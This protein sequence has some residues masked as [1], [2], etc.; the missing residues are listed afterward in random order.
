ME[1]PDTE[2]FA[3]VATCK[4]TWIGSYGFAV[5]T[6]GFALSMFRLEPS[7]GGP[8]E[9]LAPRLGLELTTH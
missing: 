8:S 4:T 6:P 1:E 5:L 9:T 3:P 7:L 2:D